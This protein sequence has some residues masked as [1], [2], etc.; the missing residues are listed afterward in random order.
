M[1]RPQAYLINRKL[2]WTIGV[3]SDSERECL[4]NLA[5][6]MKVRKQEASTIIEDLFLITNHLESEE[7]RAAAAKQVKD[8]IKKLCPCPTN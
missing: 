5:S 3:L 4:S 8:I 6:S 1:S 7:M 2:H